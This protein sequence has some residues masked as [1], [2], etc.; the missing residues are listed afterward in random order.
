MMIL[1]LIPWRN[2]Y[3][4]EVCYFYTR[5]FSQFF[6]TNSKLSLAKRNKK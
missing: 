5:Y 6:S 4:Y 3:R 1:Q 2:Y